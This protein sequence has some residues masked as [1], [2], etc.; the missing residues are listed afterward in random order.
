MHEMSNKLLN[1][2]SPP[3]R[4]P[5]V[6]VLG[7]L[8][9]DALHGPGFLRGIVPAHP[10]LFLPGL[11]SEPQEPAYFNRDVPRALALAGG[12][13]IRAPPLR[14]VAPVAL[15]DTGAETQITPLLLKVAL[16]FR[17]S[18][19]GPLVL[20]LPKRAGHYIAV[21]AVQMR[22]IRNRERACEHGEG[23]RQRNRRQEDHVR[24]WEE[25]MSW[26]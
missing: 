2:A 19:R 10:A 1:S 22:A 23:T 11:A 12:E 4:V 16:A 17:R 26:R 3:V 20:A 18:F 25:C 14:D 8:A 6:D 5:E 15:P 21:F 24:A 7:S 9:P 13:V